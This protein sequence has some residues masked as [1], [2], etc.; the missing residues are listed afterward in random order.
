MTEDVI[1]EVMRVATYDSF[2]KGIQ[3]LKPAVK[4][5]IKPILDSCKNKIGLTG[6][7][8]NPFGDVQMDLEEEVKIPAKGIAPK[9][10]TAAA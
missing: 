3:D 7:D 2:L 6:G 5:T 8:E 9:P 10:S 4:Q 1:L